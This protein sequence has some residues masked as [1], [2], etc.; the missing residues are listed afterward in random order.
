MPEPCLFCHDKRP[1]FD[2]VD[3]CL[4]AIKE[5][6]ASESFLFRGEACLFPATLPGTRRILEDGKLS[7]EQKSFFVD[8]TCMF[9][10]W[11]EEHQ[12]DALDDC[13]MF[14]Q[15]Y[16]LPTDLLDFTE[17]PRIAGYFAFKDMPG[18]LGRIGVLPR[19]IAMQKGLDLVR[20]R[21]FRVEGVRL[22]RPHKQEAWAVRHR[23]GAPSNFQEPAVCDQLNLRWF[24][25]TKKVCDPNL[26]AGLE[27]ILD[28]KDDLCASMMRQWLNEFSGATWHTSE[29]VASLLKRITQYL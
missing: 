1:Q 13:E 28:A 16:G 17:S 25:F 12:E 19:K 4:E 10:E 27:N 23:P 29:V 9:Q 14:L 7:F 24:T 15:H 21:D 22:V 26:F 8:A 20:L 11:Y 6:G 18:H 2:D 5:L 3:S